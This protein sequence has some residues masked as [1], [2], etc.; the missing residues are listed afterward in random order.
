M[1]HGL[2]DNILILPDLVNFFVTE[3][4]GWKLE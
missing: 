2:F 1:F 4:R 3:I